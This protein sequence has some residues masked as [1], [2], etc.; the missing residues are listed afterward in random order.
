MAARVSERMA[1][2][3]GDDVSLLWLEVTGKCNLCCV[4]CY[5]DSSPSAPVDHVGTLRWL[6][7]IREAAELNFRG[8]QFIGGEPLLHPDIALL[9]RESR[10]AGL[11]TEVYSNLTFMRDDLW[12]IFSAEQVSLAT[13]FYSRDEA[14]HD[15]ITQRASSHKRTVA[16]IKRAVALNIPIR[17]GIVEVDSQQNAE[18]AAAY[19]RDLGVRHVQVDRL[20]RIGRAVQFG[21]ENNPVDELCGH[22][23]DARVAIDSL[24][25]AYPCVFAR[26]LPIGNVLESTLCSLVTS[27]RLTA[28]RA[29][30]RDSFACR[31]NCAQPDDHALGEQAMSQCSPYQQCNP[32]GNCNPW[33]VP[34]PAHPVNVNL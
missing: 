29:K 6:S 23:A 34:R 18:D 32:Q 7:L 17:I 26:W 1:N 4:H 16:N 20:R 33:N 14:T 8:V 2:L 30:L 11:A 5:A 10:S 25:W 15:A 27:Q 22:C 19:L 12:D 28:T 3:S 31:V 9:I 13:S 21:V 24:G